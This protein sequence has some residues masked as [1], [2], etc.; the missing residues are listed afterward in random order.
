MKLSNPNLSKIITVMLLIGFTMVS[1]NENRRIPNVKKTNRQNS[2]PVNRKT[3]VQILNELNSDKKIN[4]LD[5]SNLDLIEIPDLSN[6]DIEN[7]DL[8]YNNLDTIPIS[9]LPKKLKKLKC[10]HNKLRSFRSHNTVNVKSKYDNSELD[11]AELDLSYNNLISVNYTISIWERGK[12]TKKGNMQKVNISNNKLEYV[13]INCSNI[14][15]LDISNNTSLSNV[16]D[17]K[18]EQIETV[19]RNNIKNMM[20]LMMRRFPD[21]GIDE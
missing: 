21:P 3:I 20:P 17:F 10:T 1:C 7:L 2:K 18:V 13:S 16:F 9:R 12:L 14:N 15:Y 4:H 5:L 6:Y 11:L 19:K 8:S